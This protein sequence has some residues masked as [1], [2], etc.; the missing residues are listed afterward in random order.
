LSGEGASFF[1]AGTAFSVIEIAG[2]VGVLL[3]GLISDKIGQRVIIL[4]STLVMPLF[5]LLFLNVEGWLQVPMLIG[6]GFLAFSA[7]PAFLSI[8]QHHFPE[9]RSLANGIYMAAS[10]VIRSLVV[11]LV[12]ALADRF[13][14]RTVFIASA[15]GAFLA[16]PIIF[17]MPKK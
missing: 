8:V 2:T 13:G 17:F 1:F 9:N 3:C 4:L 12:G 16:L 6:T 10:F 5:S 7:N 11:I 15:W 14:L